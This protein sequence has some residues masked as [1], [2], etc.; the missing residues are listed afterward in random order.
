[1]SPAGAF[2]Q[3]LFMGGVDMKNTIKMLY[4]D[5]FKCHMNT[6]R[7]HYKANFVNIDSASDHSKARFPKWF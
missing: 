2:L 3:R 6:N 5:R 1:M 7:N 4:F